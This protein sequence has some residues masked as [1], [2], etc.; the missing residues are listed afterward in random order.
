MLN[1]RYKTG[2]P[3]NPNQ[4]RQ[5]TVLTTP[6]SALC[7]FAARLYYCHDIK[8]LGLQTFYDEIEMVCMSIRYCLFKIVNATE[9]K[10]K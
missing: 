3:K 8:K 4:I 2:F 9:N 6:D 1:L 7:L 5:L 10:K